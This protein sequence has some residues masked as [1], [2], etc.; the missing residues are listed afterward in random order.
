MKKRVGLVGFGG[1]GKQHIKRIKESRY[2]EIVGVFDT[3]SKKDYSS[4]SPKIKK[5]ESL[6]SLL[7]DPSIDIIL[8]A[9]PNDTHK[10]IA[11]QALQAGKHV[12][13][14][15]PVTLNTLELKEILA[16][17][18]K[19]GK[20]FT[21]HQN[22]RWDEN[23]LITKK[24][25]EEKK[26]GEL[27]YVENRVQGSRGIP[28]DWRRNKEQGG[29]M[30]L[31]WGVHLIDRILFLF[32]N[33]KIVNLH[34]TLNYFL[35]HEVDDGFK[36]E[37]VFASSQ[38]AYLE[39]GTTNFIELPEWYT[40]GSIGTAVIEDFELNGKYVTLTGELAKEAV[41]VETGAG[42][43][44]TMAPRND[45]SIETRP[46]PDVKSNVVEFYDNFALSIDG[47]AEPFIRKEELLRL[48]TIIDACFESSEKNEIIHFPN[49]L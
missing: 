10:T 13:S 20:K 43:T 39:V 33:Q 41:P 7:D 5:F 16:A 42:L 26:L 31:D 1:M 48:T 34:A 22:R 25:V 49:G 11:I 30:L 19:Y 6:E 12:I 15:K 24:L 28:N 36:I 29:G 17:A 47:K 46:L 32:P 37:I 44:K 40:V 45:D 18:E 4:I 35:D 21:V 2:A 27:L 9:T 3:D 38:K 14:E 8:I 23:F